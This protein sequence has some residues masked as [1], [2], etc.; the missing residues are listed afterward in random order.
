MT[1]GSVG[2]LSATDVIL[3]FSSPSEGGGGGD[4]EQIFIGE[5]R[6]A[7]R[8]RQLMNWMLKTLYSSPSATGFTTSSTPKEGDVLVPEEE[9]A[10]DTSAGKEVA[11]QNRNRM[12][13]VPIQC[14]DV[15]VKKRSAK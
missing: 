3:N 8:L 9:G 5:V 13:N 1:V 10:G 12:M 11:M 2:F 15:Q 14:F 6:Y 4:I 7:G